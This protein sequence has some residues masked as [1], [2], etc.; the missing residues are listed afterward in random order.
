MTK[1]VSKCIEHKIWKLIDSGVIELSDSQAGFRP[2]RSRYDQIF[3]LRCAQ[4]HYHPWKRHGVSHHEP[5][6]LYS[7]FLDISKAYDSVP[8]IKIMERLRDAGVPEYLTRIVVDLLSNRTTTIYGR[9]IPVDRGVPQGDP[10]SPLLFILVLHPL[11]K[12]LEECGAEGAS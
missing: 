4:D 12:K 11:S 2:A 9:S 10:L 1:L 6:T 8:H 5:R 3:L 7:V